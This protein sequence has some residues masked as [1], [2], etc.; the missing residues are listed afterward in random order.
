MSASLHPPVRQTGP[1]PTSPDSARHPCFS[2]GAHARWGRVHLPVAPRCNIAC[3]F[4]DRRYS[5]LNESRPGVTAGVLAPEEAVELAVRQNR[6][7]QG[8][9]SVAGIAGPGDPLANP[10]QTLA[11]LELASRRLPGIMLCLSTN[12]LALPDWVDELVALG[13]G[14]LTVTVNAATPRTGARI[15]LRAEDAGRTLQG[16]EATSLLLARQREGIGRASALGIAV[17]VNTVVVPGVN[18]GEVEA[19]AR[20]ARAWGA[21]LMNCIPLIPVPGTP[22]AFC[23]EPEPG[24]L[25]QVRAQAERHLPQMRHCTR[26]RADACGLLGSSGM[27]GDL[28]SAPSP[29]AVSALGRGAVRLRQ[30][31]H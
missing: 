31:S 8:R 28:P 22:L 15:Y 25:Q 10:E 30:T 12:G 16:E 19:I 6:L 3:G 23:G 13:V 17:K 24:T 11:A 27:L 29:F 18:D 26:C 9:L 4:C 7:L 14:H 1:V 21:G 20:Q 5:C 2:A